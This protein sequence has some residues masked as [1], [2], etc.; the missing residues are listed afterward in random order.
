M[1][2]V[3][4]FDAKMRTLI[5]AVQLDPLDAFEN[6]GFLPMDRM[7]CRVELPCAPMSNTY[8]LPRSAVSFEEQVYASISNRLQTLDVE[9]TR[10][11]G[12]NVYVTR[13]ITP[14]TKII[15]TRLINP[16]EG[17]RLAWV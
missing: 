15:T 8:K 14:G 4:R 7:F 6:T 3:V 16:L 9:V 11:D 1:D 2:R 10:I 5:V 13:G 12:D 17:T